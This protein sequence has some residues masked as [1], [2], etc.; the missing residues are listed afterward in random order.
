MPYPSGWADYVAANKKSKTIDPDYSV[1]AA[2]Y[3]LASEFLGLEIPS[4]GGDSKT[5][6]SAV[7]KIGFAFSCL[8]RVEV[9]LGVKRSPILAADLAMKIRSNRYRRL[10]ELAGAHL[11]NDKARSAFAAFLE[12]ESANLRPFVDAMRH[13]LFHGRFTPH[14]SGLG[15][16]K[17]LL[18]L[19]DGVSQVTLRTADEKISLLLNPARNTQKP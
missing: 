3:R 9:L 5:F 10:A 7:A 14:S 4:M 13:S 18:A 17:G 15:V 19:L 2:R 12:S 16:T 1:V 11:D 8:D 6:Y